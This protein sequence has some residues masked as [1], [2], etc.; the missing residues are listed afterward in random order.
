M[1]PDRKLFFIPAGDSAHKSGSEE[2][3]HGLVQHV[4]GLALPISVEQKITGISY[5][6]IPVESYY[7]YFDE[8]NNYLGSLSLRNTALERAIA[9]KLDINKGCLPIDTPGSYANIPIFLQEEKPPTKEINYKRTIWLLWQ[10][11]LAWVRSLKT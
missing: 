11:L 9:I 6:A 1:S 8:D 7:E 3:Y 2:Y 4:V 5:S 10:Q